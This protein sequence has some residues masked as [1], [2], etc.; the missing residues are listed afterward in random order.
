MI[1][2]LRTR[3]QIHANDPTFLWKYILRALAIVLALTSTGLIGWSLA[4][5]TLFPT[6]TFDSYLFNAWPYYGDDYY[7]PWEFITLGLSILWNVA[8][9]VVVLYRQRPVHPG[10]NV[11]CDLL[12]WLGFIVTGTLATQGAE[13]FLWYY[14]SGDEFDT[15]DN[16][17]NAKGIIMAV[18]AALSFVVMVMHFA[19]FIS[20]CRY[21][22]ARR[23]NDSATLIAERMKNEKLSRDGVAAAGRERNPNAGFVPVSE[24]VEQQTPLNYGMPP[25]PTGVTVGDKVNR[26]AEEQRGRD[27]RQSCEQPEVV[28]GPGGENLAAAAY[29]NNAHET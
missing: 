11:A 29:P 10:A 14:P 2:P 8:N 22:S 18:G 6:P 23:L 16:V 26:W 13:I 9:I 27:V 25:A 24:R 21:T 3:Q 1:P 4:H 7:M 12:L 15:D 20:A 5:P 17:S 19:L 28:C